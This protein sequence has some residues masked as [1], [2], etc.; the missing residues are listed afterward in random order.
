MHEIFQI[1][2]KMIDNDQDFMIFFLLIVFKNDTLRNTKH[3]VFNFIRRR[4]TIKTIQ[5]NIKIV[6]KSQI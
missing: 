5:R 3:D 2:N 4:N 6:R 1:D